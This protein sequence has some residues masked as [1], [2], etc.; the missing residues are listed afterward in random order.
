MKGRRR[1]GWK[2]DEVRRLRRALQLSQQAFAE[3]L[4][5]RQQTVS[6]WETGMYTPRGASVRLLDIVAEQV[7]F[8]Y[9]ADPPRPEGG[10]GPRAD[11]PSP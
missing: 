7:G 10:D 3:Q 8:A 11:E 2:A 9:G 5:V 4:G 6:E 1:D